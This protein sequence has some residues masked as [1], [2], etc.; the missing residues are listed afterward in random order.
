MADYEFSD[1]ITFE[2][3]ARLIPSSRTTKRNKS[4]VF[5]WAQSGL[6]TVKVGGA[7]FTTEKWLREFFEGPRVATASVPTTNRRRRRDE[8]TSQ[9]LDKLGV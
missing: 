4:T 9:A 3:A 5:R 6:R 7:R 8:A 2:E 1:L